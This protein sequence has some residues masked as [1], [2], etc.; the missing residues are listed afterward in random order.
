V[1]TEAGK[2]MPVDPEPVEGGNIMLTREQESSTGTPIAAY[3]TPD[4]GVMRHV[5]HF[6]TCPNAAQHRKQ[7]SAE[8]ETREAV[9]AD[10]LQDAIG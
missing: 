6:A 4:P 1:L 10:D 3:V 2:R 5:S 8:P 9:S 7:P